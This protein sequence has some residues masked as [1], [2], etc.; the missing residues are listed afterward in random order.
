MPIA[1]TH[2]EPRLPVASGPLSAAVCDLLRR[3]ARASHAFNHLPTADIDPYGRDL[4]L[5]LYV[6]YELHYRGFAGVDPGWEWDATLLELRAQ[7]EHAFLDAVRQDVGVIP[8]HT[9]ARAEMDAAATEPVHGSGPSWYLRDQG[10]W[11]QA[12]EYFVHRSL[13]HLKEG[14]PHAWIIPRLTGQAK[15]SFV[16]IEFDEYGAGRGPR[17]HQQLFADLLTAAGLDAGYLAYLDVVPAESLAVVNLMSL[18]GLHRRWRGAAAGH[19]AAT[20]ITSPPGSSR[21]V[22]ALHRMGAPEPCVAFYA[23]HVEADAVHEQVV[24]TDVIGSLLDH[25]PHLETDVVFGMR[26]LDTVEN[27]LADLMTTAWSAGRSSLLAR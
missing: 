22:A 12:R 2:T 4:H 7:L 1:A 13:Y 20:E 16:A 15:A 19:F 9:T 11:E 10:T 14:D 27:R 5:A 3:P 17:V 21:L 23:E 25:N 26:A 18:F 8:P 6:C 24:R